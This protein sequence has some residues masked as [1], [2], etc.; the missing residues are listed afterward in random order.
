MRHTIRILLSLAF[1]CG[2][3]VG[4]VGTASA[5]PVRASAGYTISGSVYAVPPVRPLD[6]VEVALYQSNGA[7]G[8]SRVN[9]TVP[10]NGE[11]QFND[12]PAGEYRVG[13]ERPANASSPLWRYPLPLFWSNYAS[14]VESATTLRVVGD[15]QLSS[16]AAF[17]NSRVSGTLRS[18]VNGAPLSGAAVTLY[19]FAGAEAPRTDTVLTDRFGEYSIYVPR[20]DAN[21]FS[22]RFA[23]PGYVTEFYDDRTRLE[24]TERRSADTWEG[25]GGWL[26]AR[27]TGAVAPSV[28]TVRGRGTVRVTTTLR[29][30]PTGAP[31]PNAQFR[32][33][34]SYNNRTWSNIGGVL[35]TGSTGRHVASTTVTRTTY[36]RCVPLSSSKYLGVTS[37]SVKVSKL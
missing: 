19:W 30:G 11:Y 25:L 34:R 16:V 29:D 24:D 18:E 3:M 7:G 13:V 17:E 32:L 5:E 20:G 33:Q 1:A 22:L 12:V 21:S 27:I 10:L 23:K 26:R 31:K 4:S 37:S 8:W 9:W 35:K 6:E 36:F 15:V 2:A 14:T 28:R